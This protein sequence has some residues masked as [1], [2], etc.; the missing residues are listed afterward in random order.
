MA[1]PARRLLQCPARR[2]GVAVV[3]RV[4]TQS[5]SSK[6]LLVDLVPGLIYRAASQILSISIRCSAPRS[7]KGAGVGSLSV[8]NVEFILNKYTRQVYHLGKFS[9]RHTSLSPFPYKN[10]QFKILILS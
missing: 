9:Y 3:G 7:E 1:A 6:I 10:V 4:L 2:G 8:V 5:T